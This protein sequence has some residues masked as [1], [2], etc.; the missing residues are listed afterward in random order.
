MKKMKERKTALARAVLA[1][2][3]AVLA[4]S[5]ISITAAYTSGSP[6]QAGTG[7]ING[8]PIGT[9]QASTAQAQP[10]LPQRQPPEVETVAGSGSHGH[11]DGGLA[12]FNMPMAL[13]GDGK[14]GLIVADTFNNLIRAIDAYRDV[15]TLAGSIRFIGFDNFPHGAYL[16]GGLE[17]AGFSRPRG[18]A[19][20][21]DGWVFIADSGNHAIRVIVGGEVFTF[22]GGLGAGHADGDANTARFNSPSALAVCP[23]GY[24]Y[25]ADTGN[26]AIRRVSPIGV[27]ETI[28]GMPGSYGYMNGANLSALFDSP[29]GIALSGSGRIYVSDTGNHAIRVISGISGTAS[30]RVDTFAGRRAFLESGGS[31]SSIHPDEWD[32]APAG[33]F[34][35]GASDRAM[36]NSPKGLSFWGDML[37]VADSSNHSIRI[38]SPDG[39]ARTLAG[40]GY[41]DYIGGAIEAAAFHFPSGVYVF[42]DRLFIADMGNNKIRSLSLLP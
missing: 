8:A 38:I 16:D 41:P 10:A 26:H 42:E 28:A 40:T 31:G 9:A 18:I 15:Q 37:I 2:A 29:M 22:A 23:E 35:D 21:P 11:W 1:Q 19:V 30:G 6:G 12:R 7:S 13:A 36:F 33:G 17:T 34:E 3:A 32:A 20:N 24:V 27:T 14:G 39:E 25:V 5:L 4:L